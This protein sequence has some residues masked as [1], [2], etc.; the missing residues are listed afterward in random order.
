MFILVDGIIAGEEEGPLY[1]ASK[2]CGLLLA[3]YNPV[4]VD[5]VCSRIMGFDYN[6]IPLFKYVMNSKQYALYSYSPED[7]MIA[8]DRCNTFSEVYASYGCNFIPSKGWKG[9]IEYNAEREL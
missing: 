5:L 9:H 4:A 3:G 7:I 8:S 6:K 1:P 2:Q